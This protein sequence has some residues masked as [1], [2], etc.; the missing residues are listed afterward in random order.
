[1][2][3]LDKSY[4]YISKVSWYQENAVIE[5]QT[6]LYINIKYTAWSNTNMHYWFE[7]TLLQHHFSLYAKKQTDQQIGW[8]KPNMF[9]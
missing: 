1:M 5:P 3:I 4:Y 6:L 9:V 7:S 8:K 2:Y